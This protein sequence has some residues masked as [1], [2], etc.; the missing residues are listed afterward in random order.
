M[1]SPAWEARGWA[2]ATWP[3]RLS[4]GEREAKGAPTG[5]LPPQLSREAA[6]ELGLEQQ[7][8]EEEEEEEAA[9]RGS[10]VH[11]STRERMMGV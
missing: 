3:L 4:T 7:V 11:R 8:E 9:S 1:S 6:G 5:R 10:T 2:E